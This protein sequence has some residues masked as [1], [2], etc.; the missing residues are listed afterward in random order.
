MQNKVKRTVRVGRNNPSHNRVRATVRKTKSNENRSNNIIMKRRYAKHVIT[1]KRKKVKDVKVSSIKGMEQTSDRLLQGNKEQIRNNSNTFNKSIN[2]KRI[3]VSKGKK[4]KKIESVTKNVTEKE[5]HYY[6]GVKNIITAN[7]AANKSKI[8]FH[9][10]KKE[11]LQKKIQHPKRITEHKERGK[12][13]NRG[14]VKDAVFAAAKGE[15]E[16]Q[17]GGR[18]L[19]EATETLNTSVRGTA[20]L[21]KTTV[22]TGKNIYR[23]GKETAQFIGKKVEEYKETAAQIENAE[24]LEHAIIAKSKRVDE[25]SEPKRRMAGVR[26]REE[27]VE[28][29]NVFQSKKE[30][31]SKNKR[32]EE[33]KKRDSQKKQSIARKRMLT[34]IQNKTSQDPEKNDSIGAVAKDILKGKGKEIG[35]KL[36][37]ALGKKI[38]YYLGAAL[39]G[40]IVVMA[41]VIIIVVL[42]YSSPFA[43]FFSS[44]D[45]ETTIQDVLTEYYTEFDNKVQKE[46]E[47]DGYDRIIVKSITGE[48]D[49]GIS[50]SNYKDVLCIFAEKYGYDLQIAD[51]SKKVKKKLKTVFDDMNYYSTKVTTKTKTNKKGETVQK[52]ILTITITQKTWRDM[53]TAYKF[54]DESQKEV[55]ELLKLVDD[56]DMGIEIPEDEDYSTYAGTDTC[57]DGKVYDNPNAPVYKGSCAKIAKKTKKYI[58]PILKKKGMEPYI[59]IIVSMVQQEST[60]GKGDN[61]NWMQVNGYKGKPGM[62]S[63]KAGIDQFAGLIKICKQKKITDIKVLVQS[64]NM[65]QGYISFIKKNGG[66][67]KVSLQIK[68]QYKQR[69]DGRY[70]TAGYSNSVMSRV[71]GQKPKIKIMPLYYQY[72]SKWKNKSYGSSTIGKSGCGVCSSA[73]VASYWTGKQITPPKITKWASNYY[74]PGAG[75]SHNLYAAVAKK[76]N[77]KY[78]DLGLN[79]SEMVKE[80]KKGHTVIASMGP[81]QF[82]QNSHLIV[83]RT[84][85]NGKIRV[86]DPNDSSIKNHVNKKYTPAAIHKEAKHYWSLYK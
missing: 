26:S 63:V 46:E 2:I 60:F 33:Q 77:L 37:S 38:L 81:G 44:D 61:A 19:I 47:E 8:L 79:K 71:K 24:K 31:K 56:P 30:E 69:S 59:D 62:A 49:V 80:L 74:I 45:Q 83:L 17:Q 4:I 13:K 42:L 32:K 23:S 57:I 50:R 55:K 36:L 20:S 43:I 10:E 48:T 53:V 67:D 1:A 28:K 14:F 52:K 7:A 39:G 73:M 84:I 15:L 78:R 16:S 72:D 54:D 29:K 12:K 41:P 65:G 40:L 85:E 25:S 86:N 64:Y 70:G 11:V 66:K 35:K 75:S 58:R 21:I 68:F 82:T 27:Y 18:E 5:K 34:Y 22:E 51:V 6:Q 76:Y 9:P 3:K